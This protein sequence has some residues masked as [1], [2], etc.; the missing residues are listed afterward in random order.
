MTVPISFEFF[1]AR[2]P[3]SQERLRETANAL[4][5]VNPEFFSI[6]FGAGGGTRD[7]T[8]DTTIRLKKET[9]IRTVP[10]I[11]CNML[12]AEE[13]EEMLN[14]YK[15]V[16]VSEIV[17]LRGDN[18]SGL[19]A[20]GEFKYASELVTFIKNKYADD[21]KIN[22]AAYPEVHPQAL[23]SRDD[24]QSFRRKVAAGAH[25]GITQYFYNSDS[26][27]YFVDRCKSI[28]IDIPII[29]GIMPITNYNSLERFS[30]I[31]GAEIPKWLARECE[32]LRD[33]QEAL[34]NFGVE[35][36]TQLCRRLI[37][38]GAPKLHFYS[39]NQAKLP[40]KICTNL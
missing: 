37:A 17:A 35:V 34:E 12:T 19:V 10:H 25:A 22:V 14:K 33:D 8:F 27:F 21:F 36:V 15:S 5:S 9:G 29:P 32:D 16:G 20:S 38:G 7:L 24:L 6:T 4:A 40:L 31:C 11:S 39:M 13:I 28:G 26:Y 2:G 1:P 30:R 18:P 23:S 3:E